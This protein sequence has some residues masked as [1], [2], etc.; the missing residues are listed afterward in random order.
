MNK[1][2]ILHLSLYLLITLITSHFSCKYKN[3]REDKKIN[4]TGMFEMQLKSWSFSG[5]TDFFVVYSSLP[6]TQFAQETLIV[7]KKYKNEQ[8][9]PDT[10]KVKISKDREDSIYYYA[11]KYV[12]NFKINDAGDT[13]YV[14][15]DGLNFSISFEGHKHNKLEAT[16]YITAEFNKSTDEASKL[17]AFLNKIVPENFKIN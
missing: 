13:T 1:K 8:Q 3:N 14:Y 4:N 9:S 5:E 15:Q 16:R 7:I 12:S 17:V 10:L 6:N 11:Y 2:L